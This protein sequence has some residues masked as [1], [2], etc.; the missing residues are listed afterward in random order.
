[1]TVVVTGIGFVTPYGLE[2]AAILQRFRA[3]ES[4]AVPPPENERPALEHPYIARVPDDFDP[5]HWVRRRKELK[6]MARANVLAVAAARLA[7]DDAGLAPGE[8]LEDAGLYLGVGQEPGDLDDVLPAVAH[9]RD[10]AGEHLDLARLS[11]DGLGQMNPL[12][13]IKTLPNMSH[14]HVAISLGLRGPGMTLCSGPG[15]GPAALEAAV[16]ALVTG[17]AD[18][19]LAGAADA[20]IAFSDRVSAARRGHLSPLA[21]AAV[22][23]VL[24]PAESAAARGARVLALASDI[25]AAPDGQPPFGDAGAASFLVSRVLHVLAGEALG[26]QSSGRAPA[27]LRNRPPRAVA[28]TGVGLRT[29]LG[30]DFE[31]FSRALLSGAS[32][33]ASITAFPSR[34]FPVTLAC[35]VPE[36]PLPLPEPL[37]GRMRGLDDRKGEL[38]L[39]AALAAVADAPGALIPETALIYGTGLSSVSLAELEEDCLPYLNAAGAYDYALFGR[40]PSPRDPQAP[41]RH[42]VERPM[43]L[44]AG[45][46]G[47]TGRRAH[48]FSACAAGAAAIG[49]AADLVREG[50][51]EVALAGAA[52]SMIHPFGLLPFILLGATSPNPDPATAARPFDQHRDGFVM[53]EAGAFYVLEPLE[54]ALGAGRRVYGLILGHGT[55]SDAFNVTAPHPEGRGAELA[56]RRALADA[57]LAPEAVGYINAHGTG[58]PLNDVIEAAAIRRVFG[59]RCP[60]VSS[61]KGQFG[62]AI[63]AAG[64]VELAVCLAAL[65]GERLPPNPTLGQ[66]DARIDLDLVERT[67]RPGAPRVALS[68]SFGFG[69]QNATLVVGRADTTGGN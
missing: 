42:A 6:L 58:T 35:Q 17:R 66:V 3:R 54:R 34:G 46:L 64:A 57:G 50:D 32:A 51:V 55:S 60:P 11:T 31:T 63:A 43:D 1:V 59:E 30:G 23:L 21:E 20:P 65:A 49:H 27:V 45:H 48:H 7:L 33:V 44:L 38:A 12:S 56:M 37:A 69:G 53:G 14:A 26:P 68:N 8:A 28:I 40:S 39:A 22:L 62:H 41:R 18:R 47:L 29:P 5:T 4:V 2:T 24:E 13:S 15:A 67:G 9:S 36:R 52:D 25:L 61:S 10:P 16:R 19:V